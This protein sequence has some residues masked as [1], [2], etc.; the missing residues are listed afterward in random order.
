MKYSKQISERYNKNRSTYRSTNSALFPLVKKIGV[1]N[2][3]ILDFGCGA[4]DDAYN[5]V[6]IGASK[7]IGVDVSESMIKQAKKNYQENSKLKFKHINSYSL[8]FTN[9]EFD[10][11]FSHFVIHYI[12]D[13]RKQFK[14]IS[15]TLKKDGYFI[16]IFNC[17]AINNKSINKTVPMVLGKGTSQI[18]IEILSKS[19][20]EV[21]NALKKAGMNV[22]KFSRV[23]NP[24]IKFDPQPTTRK[25]LKK[26]TF[27]FL[28]QKN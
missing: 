6:G 22:L 7:V 11:V 16:A 21:K 15:R 10:L 27:L 2:K 8:P 18:K 14:E 4:G 19:A 12:K 24:D 23:A 13:L 9:Q 26:D 17:L 20:D 5:F 3:M 28:A 25:G 1:K